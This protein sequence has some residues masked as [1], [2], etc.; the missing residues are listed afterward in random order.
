MPKNVLLVDDETALLLALKKLLR[1]EVVEI[2]TAETKTEAISFLEKVSCEVVIVDLKLSGILNQ[3][4][5]DI[6]QYVKSSKPCT[7]VILITGYGSPEIMEYAYTLGADFYF[8]KP[9]SVQVLRDA[10][11]GLGVQ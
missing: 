5:I 1:S 8:E 10:L 7:G 4:G 11:K 3:D 9:V 2:I 6:L